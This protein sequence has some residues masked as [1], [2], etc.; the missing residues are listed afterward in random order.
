M[1]YNG[2]L[3]AKYLCRQLSSEFYTDIRK[4]RILMNLLKSQQSRA[5]DACWWMRCMSARRGRN[6]FYFCFVV[7]FVIILFKE[8]VWGGCQAIWQGARRRFSDRALFTAA[9]GA[10]VYRNFCLNTLLQSCPSNTFRLLLLTLKKS[11]MISPNSSRWNGM[12]EMNVIVK[13]CE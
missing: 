12:D 2:L 7:R 3:C 6:K 11:A 5:Y 8:E 1:D 4:R 13:C 10:G 9:I